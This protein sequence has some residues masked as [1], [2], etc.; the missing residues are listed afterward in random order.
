MHG[1][2]ALFDVATLPVVLEFLICLTESSLLCITRHFSIF[3]DLPLL[4]TSCLFSISHLYNTQAVVTL[5]MTLRRYDLSLAIKP[6]E[7][8]ILDCV[9][10]LNSFA[11]YMLV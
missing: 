3:H 9:N 6:E 10:C 8:R 7:V 1:G 4:L 11:P 2:T 5:A